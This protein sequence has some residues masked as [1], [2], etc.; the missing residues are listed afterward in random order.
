MILSSMMSDLFV[1]DL[2]RVCA[3][4]TYIFAYASNIRAYATYILTYA[5]TVG[6]YATYIFTYTSTV[7]AYATYIFAYA[8]TVE[9]YATYIFAHAST[10]EA[11][12]LYIFIYKSYISV[13]VR[14]FS[15]VSLVFFANC[16]LQTANFT[17][18]RFHI[19][20]TSGKIIKTYLCD[21]CKYCLYRAS[22]A[23]NNLE[24]F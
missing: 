22:N 15:Y 24:S 6:A 16:Q 20:P 4:L 19:F 9:A 10:V 8:S 3:S 11:Y 7:G 23:D 17:P 21:V 5:S 1:P 2:Q 13:H 18:F 14:Y 12:E